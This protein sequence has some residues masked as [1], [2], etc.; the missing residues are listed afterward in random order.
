LGGCLH[1]HAATQQTQHDTGVEQTQEKTDEEQS[2]AQIGAQHIQQEAQ[3]F[4]DAGAK[5][6]KVVYESVTMQ[7]RG[8]NDGMMKFI[9]AD[10]EP[11]CT[12]CV[13]TQMYAD[14][15]YPNGTSALADDGMWLHHALFKN[16]GKGSSTKAALS[17]RETLQTC[18]STPFETF[19]ASGNERSG[20]DLTLGGYV[21]LVQNVSFERNY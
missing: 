21:Q 1:F 12:G 16:E 14:L 10:A 13:I 9:I 19:F 8:Q 6:T 5:R 7:G 3:Y 18:N 2:H 15:E 11:P 4:R 20:V 17:K